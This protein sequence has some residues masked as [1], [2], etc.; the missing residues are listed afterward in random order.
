[1]S[2]DARVQ[3]FA[4]RFLSGR[5][6]ELIVEPALA[7][8]Q[9][10]QACGRASLGRCRLA[11]LR[12]VFGGL[13]ADLRRGSMDFLAL[14]MMPVCY[15]LS[16]VVICFDFFAFPIPIARGLIAAAVLLLVFAFG[17]VMVCFWPERRSAE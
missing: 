14:T 5:A 3:A 17:P 15:Y 8:L 4:A 16:L 1:M 10:E 11:V 2:F 7:D 6:F 13:C 9:F 12:A